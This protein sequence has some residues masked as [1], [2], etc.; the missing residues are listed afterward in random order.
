MKNEQYDTGIL[1]A[2]FQVK[3]LQEGHYQL[4]QDLIK[5]HDHIITFICISPL[6]TTKKNP[7]D[8]ETRKA[9]INQAFPE[10]TVLPMPDMYY[11]EEWSRELDKRIAEACPDKNVLLY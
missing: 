2:R 6:L 11:D 10:I 5:S 3:E 4:L 1:V 9:M 8:F 7:L